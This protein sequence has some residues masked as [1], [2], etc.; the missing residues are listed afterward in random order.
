M[1]APVV[2][3]ALPAG[4]RHQRHGASARVPRAGRR[5]GDR[6]GAAGRGRAGRSVAR[7]SGAAGPQPAAAPSGA[8]P[9]R[10]LAGTMRRQDPLDQARAHASTKIRSSPRSRK[11]STR[12]LDRLESERRGLHDEVGQTLTGVMLQLE[13]LPRS[14]SE[15]R[16]QLDELREN[17]RQGTEDVRRIASRL[18]PGALG[19]SHGIRG[20]CVN[21]PYSLEASSASRVHRA[22][23]LKCSS[24]SPSVGTA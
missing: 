23:A 10:R 20:I 6:V 5:T 14:P 24:P 11:R 19:S 3:A 22:V 2:A 12:T 15:L 21:A 9:A 8:S 17:A 18:R 4:V 1:Q 16:E 7:S 13:G